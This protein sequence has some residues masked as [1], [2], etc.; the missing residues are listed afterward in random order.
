MDQ[1]KPALDLIIEQGL[2][3]LYFHPDKD[4]SVHVM[5]AL[6]NA[7]VRIIE[8]TNRGKPALEN[9]LHLRKIADKELPGLQLGAGTI[10]SKKDAAGFINEG[11]DFIVCPGMIEEIADVVNNNDL[12]MDTRLYDHQQK[13]S[14]PKIRTP[15]L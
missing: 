8:Y 15:S 2:V 3:P 1:K 12:V 9:F 11:A 4:V 5:R 14:G 13:S 10:K 7:G 6:Y